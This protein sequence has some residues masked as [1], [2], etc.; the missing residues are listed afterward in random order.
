MS[1]VSVYDVAR[2]TWY[3]Q[4]TTGAPGALAQGCAVVASAQDGSSHQVYWYGGFDGLHPSEEFSDDVWVL[5]VPSFTWTKLY[6][7]TASHARA[8]HRCVKPYPDQMFVIGGYT[9]LSGEQPSC[10]EGGII[11]VFNL[12]DGNWVDSYD[13]NRWSNYTVPPVLRN[14]I[15]GTAT[16][17]ASRSHPPGGFHNESMAA[18]F[19][20][21]YN[22]SKSTTWYPYRASQTSYPSGAVAPQ[23]TRKQGASRYLP[24]IVGTVAALAFLIALIMVWRC[25]VV[26]HLTRG[27][28]FMLHGSHG[29]AKPSG[30]EK[31]DDTPIYEMDTSAIHELGA[32]IS[33]PP[34]YSSPKGFGVAN[35]V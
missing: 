28:Q 15:G 32:E 24:A 30:L 23:T 1:T 22:S 33:P 20:T 2:H 5:S 3:T 35:L 8:G 9:S 19:G 26:P 21:L 18:I 34:G 29:P 17:G 25:G 7:G 12:S 16:G 4:N 14:T 6:S 27:L 13:P 11:Q 10:L 31:I